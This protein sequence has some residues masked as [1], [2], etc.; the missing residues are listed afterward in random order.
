MERI[1]QESSR[2]ESS[3]EITDTPIQNV[4]SGK[5]DIK[6]WQF[7]E[8]E[9]GDVLKKI[10]YRLRQNTLK[11]GKQENLTTYFSYYATQSINKAKFA[12]FPFSRKATAE[13]QNIA[14]T[15]H[16]LLLLL[17]FLM[18]LNRIQPMI[19]KILRKNQNG[20]RRNRFTLSQ[21][22]TICWFFESVRVIN[23]NATLMFVD[24]SI[25]FYTI[26]TDQRW[27]K[28]YLHIKKKLLRL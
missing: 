3:L 10:K 18:L 12:S 13:S 25:A 20:S 21:I 8:E 1:F 19:D 27:S 14:E 2:K 9:F 6:L 26:H 24:F 17:R 7:T 23:L 28:Y 15:Y 16:S 22:L 4:I 5:L 11:I